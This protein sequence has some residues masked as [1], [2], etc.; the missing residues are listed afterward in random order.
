MNEK[1]PEDFD[2]SI[3]DMLRADDI[4]AALLPRSKKSFHLIKSAW[5]M[6]EEPWVCRWFDDGLG[7]V[8]EVT[9]IG[10]P[11]PGEKYVLFVTSDDKGNVKNYVFFTDQYH[12][13]EDQP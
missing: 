7:K 1:K 12:F 4:R 6:A 3:E 8:C 5:T 2:K 13:I 11:F 10:T 9:P